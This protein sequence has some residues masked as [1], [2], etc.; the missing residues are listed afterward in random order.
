M[1]DG[2][3]VK[4]SPI[5]CGGGLW[6]IF[7]RVALLLHAHCLTTQRGAIDLPPLGKASWYGALFLKHPYG[8]GYHL[9][10]HRQ[11]GHVASLLLS[12]V[13]EKTR[14]AGLDE[15]SMSPILG[16]TPSMGLGYLT[17][18][19]PTNFAAGNRIPAL[20]NLDVDAGP[21]VSFAFPGP[22]PLS[23][24][25]ILFFPDRRARRYTFSAI[26][27]R[28]T[29][30]VTSSTAPFMPVRSSARA[31]TDHAFVAGCLRPSLIGLRTALA[32][33]NRRLSVREKGM[34]RGPGCDPSGYSQFC[35]HSP[36]KT[37]RGSLG[38]A[39]PLPS[40]SW[41]PTFNWHRNPFA[42]T[43]VRAAQTARGSVVAEPEKGP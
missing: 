8:D 40:Q 34:Q 9:S 7:A 21:T 43:H 28:A 12:P 29:S 15:F 27:H 14:P 26:T 4:R 30:P 3:P 41:R 1:L 6:R 22:N 18:N 2:V 24:R 13:G 19:V 42:C 20:A 38:T 39:V 16:A 32:E 33:R 36:T 23:R 10:G 31:R 17:A 11:H 37:R 35:Y 5:L 25:A